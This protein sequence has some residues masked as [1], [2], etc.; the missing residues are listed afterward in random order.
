[1]AKAPRYRVIFTPIASTGNAHVA[2]PDTEA[3]EGAS[4]K[5]NGKYKI[6]LV[7]EGDDPEL[8]KLRA[9]FE[10]EAKAHY[11][12]AEAVDFPFKEGKA[13]SK[14]AGMVFFTAQSTKQPECF[15]ARN[16]EIAPEN[17]SRG[18]DRARI[19]LAL[20][21]WT[22]KDKVKERVNGRVVETEIDVFG[23]SARIY[24]LQLVEKRQAGSG[25]DEIEGGFDGDDA[26]DDNT[27]SNR[28]GGETRSSRPKAD[29]DDD[30]PF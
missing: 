29:L 30:I 10:K 19:K 8:A 11:P 17:F 13:D 5:P 23:I 26:A 15:N 7:F 20:V 2:K 16:R 27:T 22:K 3:P 6:S 1:M 25:F 28:S 4:W 18:G 14:Y 21:P 12:D 24:G 9:E